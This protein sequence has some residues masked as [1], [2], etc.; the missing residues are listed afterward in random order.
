MFSWKEFEKT[1]AVLS[2]VGGKRYKAEW[3]QHHLYVRPNELLDWVEFLTEDLGFFS[4]SEMAGMEKSG[5]NFDIEIV[6]NLLNM[7]SHQRLN[8]HLEANSFLLSRVH[9]PMLNGLKENKPR[10]LN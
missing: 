9:W 3:G 7:G 2:H 1:R 4:M 8:L 5:E 10:C 6:Y